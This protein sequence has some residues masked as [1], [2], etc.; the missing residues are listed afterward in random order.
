[1]CE[2]TESNAK[3]PAFTALVHHERSQP[4]PV[5]AHI[6][7]EQAEFDQFIEKF[8]HLKITPSTSLAGQAVGVKGSRTRHLAGQLTGVPSLPYIFLGL[9]KGVRDSS[10]SSEAVE[11]EM[12]LLG[13]LLVGG[14]EQCC[15][16][17]PATILP[18]TPQRCA[19]RHRPLG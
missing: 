7:H 10:D 6:L 4:Q 2:T 14:V 16:A 12:G 8:N 15:R 19:L 11:I 5:G 3:K 13:I 17:Y 9:I 18:S 1:V